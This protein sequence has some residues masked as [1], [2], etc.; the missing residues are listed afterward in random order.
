MNN[1]TTNIL[2]HKQSDDFRNSFDEDLDFVR[3]EYYAWGKSI[4]DNQPQLIRELNDAI[5]ENRERIIEELQKIS[6]NVLKWNL[7]VESYIHKY[8]SEENFKR[9]LES[10]L[11]QP[12]R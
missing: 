8:T 11:H 7:F 1:E 9:Q 12:H 10:Y 6:S 4:I 3:H 5:G 2:D